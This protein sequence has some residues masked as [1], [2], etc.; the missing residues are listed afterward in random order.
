MLECCGRLSDMYRVDILTSHPIQYQAPLFRK[1]AGHSDIDLLVCFCWDNRGKLDDEFGKNVYWDIPLTEGYKYE[2]LKNFSFL[3]SSKFFGQI[4]PG[5]IKKIQKENCDAL[6]V[7]GWNSF[8]NWLAFFSA[9]WRG[10][11]VL[12]RC[13]NPLL[14]ERLKSRWK[15]R[16]KKFILG[17]LFRRISAFLYIGEENRKFYKFYGVPE[18]KLFF[19]PYAVDNSRFLQK[20][21]ELR[22]K[23]IEL[24]TKIGIAKDAMVILFAGKLIPK[25]RLTDLLRAYEL[26][27]TNYQL[28]TTPKLLFVGEGELRPELEK[29]VKTHNLPNVHFA[30]FKNQTEMPEYY[31]I[32]DILVLPSGAGET[33]GLAVNE[34]M[35]FGVVPIVSDVVGCGPDLVENGV[36]GFMFPVGDYTKLLERLMDLVKDK[37]KLL[38]FSR[39]SFEKIQEYSYERDLGGLFSALR[40]IRVKS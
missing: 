23:D 14:H 5:V 10:V 2:F 1:I 11:P 15:I 32:S 39:R 27:I 24:R 4:N 30:G 12:L 20:A 35:C 8:T 38:S 7:F 18:E 6:L 21:A 3:P 40:T 34:A 22:T 9:F 37:T 19:A 26:L 17:W 29:Y 33:W 25:K 16:I 31:A 13:E 28:P 36:N